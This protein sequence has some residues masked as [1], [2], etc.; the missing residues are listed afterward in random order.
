MPPAVPLVTIICTYEPCSKPRNVL[1]C[2]AKRKKFCSLSCSARHR[3]LYRTPATLQDLQD[4][5]W[6]KVKLAGTDECWEWQGGKN[7]KGYG[8]FWVPELQAQKPAQVVQW[9]FVHGFWPA[10]DMEVCHSCDNPPCVND[11]HLWLGTHTDN[12]QDCLRKG[13]NGSLTHPE[14]ILYGEANPISKLTNAQDNELYALY[15]TGEW[16]YRTLARH[17]GVTKTA[18]ER[19]IHKHRTTNDTN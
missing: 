17:Y 10:P 19:R 2:E 11:A 4:R 3:E 7:D 8:C 12:M 5:F 16:T 14:S 1:P 13:R 18:I 6:S 15:L 9:F